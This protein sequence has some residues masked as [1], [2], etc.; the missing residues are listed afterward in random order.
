MRNELA[1]VLKELRTK[2]N[3]TQNEIA[4]LV[5]VTQ[6]AYSFYENGTREPKLDTLIQLA[7]FYRVPLD[8]LVGR[9]KINS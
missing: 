1:I 7:E 2:N 6:R 5:N 3:L 9:Y 4:R 8:I